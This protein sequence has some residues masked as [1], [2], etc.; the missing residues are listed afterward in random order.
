MSYRSRKPKAVTLERS[1]TTND[2]KKLLKAELERLKIP[3][4]KL[5]A[6]TVRF[7]VA[8]DSMIFVTIHGWQPDA[9]NYDR[10]VA[11]SRLHRFGLNFE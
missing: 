7:A 9:H 3:Y 6:R 4:D 1:I 5:S 8:R 11:F 2:A 10:I